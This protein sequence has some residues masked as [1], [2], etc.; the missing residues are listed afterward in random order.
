M[1]SSVSARIVRAISRSSSGTS[2]GTRGT[3]AA[4]SSSVIAAASARFMPSIWGARAAAERRVPPQ[5]GHTSSRRNR[6]TRARPFS[7]LALESAFSTV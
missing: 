5:S 6:D 2:S 4:S 3:Q 1:G 7:S